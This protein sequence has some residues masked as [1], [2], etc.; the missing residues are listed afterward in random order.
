MLSRLP[1]RAPAGR[2]VVATT[3]R[4]AAARQTEIILLPFLGEA[5]DL[6]VADAPWRLERSGTSASSV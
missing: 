6:I 4:Q 3:T 2:G 5:G 1:G